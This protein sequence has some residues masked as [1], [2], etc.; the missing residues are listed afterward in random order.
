MGVPEHSASTSAPVSVLLVLLVVWIV[1]AVL[2]VLVLGGIAFGVLSALHRL[3]RE[4]RG[5][6]GEL[7]PVLAEV[8]A[9]TDR[10]AAQ[11]ADDGA[12][13]PR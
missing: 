5:L 1:V 8:Q 3:I 2:A 9:T 6:E 13:T 7:R 12:M 4:L 10:I 11:R